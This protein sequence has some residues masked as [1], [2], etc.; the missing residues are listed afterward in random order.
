MG[1]LADGSVYFDAYLMLTPGDIAF[2]K[3]ITGR[4]FDPETIAAEK[5]AGTFQGD[6]LAAAIG[7]A[8]ADNVHGWGGLSGDVNESFLQSIKS[9]MSNPQG[10]GT[11][12]GLMISQAELAAAFLVL[13]RKPHPTVD[14]SA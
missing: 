2:L 4:S 3:K 7:E 8:R 10:D 13:G 11:Y 14:A 5:A 12:Q 6:P 1:V 9:A